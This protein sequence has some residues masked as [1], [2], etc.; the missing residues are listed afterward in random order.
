MYFNFSFPLINFKRALFLI[1]TVIFL[2]QISKVYIKLNFPLTLYGDDAIL[3]YGFFK[4]L[5]IENKGMAWGTKLS[6]FIPFLN[7]YVSKLL[8][9]IIRI[10]AITFLG[11]WI[12]K[13]LKEKSSN[14]FL[15]ALS[16]IFAGAVGNLLDSIFMEPSFRI[17][18]DK[19]LLFFLMRAMR[20]F[21]LATLLTCSNSQLYLGY[22]QNGFLLLEENPIHFLN[23]FLILLI[24]QLVSE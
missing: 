14:S 24:P 18:M 10:V 15:L 9:S 2:D 5:F 19:L 13:S 21:F 12:K 16:L 7:E 8:L 11:Y 17:A 3:D 23:M 20:R 22:G 1:F 6:D 4:L